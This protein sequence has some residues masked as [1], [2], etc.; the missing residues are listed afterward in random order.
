MSIGVAMPRSEAMITTE[1]NF[2]GSYELRSRR[3]AVSFNASAH[4][5]SPSRDLS[6]SSERQQGGDA[7]AR[8]VRHR[9]LAYSP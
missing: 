3:A 7:V 9:S 1:E 5:E 2:T 8:F 4:R 6:V